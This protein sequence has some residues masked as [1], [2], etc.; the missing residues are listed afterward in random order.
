MERNRREVACRPTGG[1]FGCDP[2]QQ[3]FFHQ[4]ASPHLPLIIC[5]VLTACS[6][7]GSTILFYSDPTFDFQY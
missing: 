1:Y 6:D 7:Q 5:D 2:V 4:F 3:P